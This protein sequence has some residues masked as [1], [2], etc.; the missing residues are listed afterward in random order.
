MVVDEERRQTARQR[1]RKQGQYAALRP[2]NPRR[3]EKYHHNERH[4]RCQTVHAVCQ[5]DRVDTAHDYER[6][7][8]Q[9]QRPVYADFRVQN[10][11]IERI[12]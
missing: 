6:R 8:H 4:A 3:R 11:E 10:G 12:R 1:R 9:I 7:E 5:V 2:E